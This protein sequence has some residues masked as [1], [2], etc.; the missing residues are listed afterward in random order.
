MLRQIQ[1]ADM[2]KR[3]EPLR[4]ELNELETQA[5]ENRMKG[6]EVNKLIQGLEQ[7]ISK[8]KE[9]YAV[10]ISQAQAIKADLAAVEAKVNAT[11]SRYSCLRLPH[12]PPFM[13]KYSPFLTSE[14]VSSSMKLKPSPKTAHILNSFFLS[15]HSSTCTGIFVPVIFPDQVA[16]VHLDWNSS[17]KS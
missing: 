14:L 12:L 8:Y 4:N 2:L 9:E 11:C 16:P 10:L 15:T 13:S 6:E 7:S 5:E 17:H 3:V 1:Y